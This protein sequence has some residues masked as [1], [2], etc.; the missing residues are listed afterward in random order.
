[1]KQSSAWMMFMSWA[2]TIIIKSSLIS[3]SL[4][5][6]LLSLLFCYHQRFIYIFLY[7]ISLFFS[8]GKIN[9]DISVFVIHSYIFLHIIY[10]QFISGASFHGPVIKKQKCG[11]SGS[12]RLSGRLGSPRRMSLIWSLM[13]TFA[14]AEKSANRDHLH[15]WPSWICRIF[16]AIY[17]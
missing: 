10:L 16:W 12:S 5:L 1:M 8:T 3:P 14:A 7:L 4:L 6:L 15:L 17:H 2:F 11:L 13:I 9:L